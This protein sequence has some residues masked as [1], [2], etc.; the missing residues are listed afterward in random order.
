MGPNEITH[1]TAPGDEIARP[2]CFPWPSDG[3]CVV[4]RRGFGLTYENTGSGMPDRDLAELWRYQTGFL[5]LTQSAGA[6]TLPANTTLPL[7]TRGQQNPNNTSE[8]ASVIIAPPF[9]AGSA[10]PWAMSRSETDLYKGGAPV[11]RDNNFVIRAFGFSIG[12]PFAASNAG[13]GTASKLTVVPNLDLWY[14]RIVRMLWTFL[15]V[16]AAF[17]EAACRYELGKIAYWPQ[18]ANQTGGDVVRSGAGVGCFGMLPING[19][20]F[21]G[22]RDEVNQLILNVT[23]P[24]ADIVFAAD[25]EA[26]IA[27]DILVPIDSIAYGRSSAWCNPAC[28]PQSAIDAAVE[29]ALRA[30]GQG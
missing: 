4:P 16:Q 26:A 10:V 28:P 6:L 1:A 8:D 24:T 9:A 21:A 2:A 18:H 23:S 29:R 7:W 17:G 14:Q 30:R 27:T 22:A 5:R 20:I 13:D 15:G 12:Q 19:E 11:P 3:P 25:S